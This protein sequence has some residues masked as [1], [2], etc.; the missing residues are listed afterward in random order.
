MSLPTGNRLELLVRL[1]PTASTASKCTEKS[2]SFESAP[3]NGLQLKQAI[4]N[5][6][7]IPV[8]LQTISLK[9][10]IITDGQL[11]SELYLRKDDVLTVEYT[12]EADTKDMNELLR[13]LQSFIIDD[14]SVNIEN[15]SNDLLTIEE[16]IHKCL[17]PPTSER[18]KANRFHFVSK[19]GIQTCL[20][21]Y[22]ALASIPW[23]STTIEML[24]L[25]RLIL[26]VLCDLSA[27]NTARQLLMKQPKVVEY[28]CM[29]I[30]KAKIHPYKLVALKT[31][32]GDA[33]NPQLQLIV[34]EIMIRAMG[35]ITK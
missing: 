13:L 29:S 23:P 27:A 30:L 12:T 2:I 3:E 1:R 33:V 11:L 26:F 4:E 7:Q 14:S 21:I 19:N 5:E 18:T 16:L 25:E 6:L 22:K 17:Q 32:D 20:A 10:G 35:I 15:D 28:L 24:L 31:A 8:C 34:M 9:S